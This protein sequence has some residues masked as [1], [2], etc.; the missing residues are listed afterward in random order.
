MMSTQKAAQWC[1]FIVA[2]TWK[3]PRCVS[4]GERINRLWCIWATE[5]YLTPNRKEQS[6]NEKARG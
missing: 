3:Q 2:K 4:V 6:S 1:L 5:C